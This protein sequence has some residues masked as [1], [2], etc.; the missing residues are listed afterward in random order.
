MNGLYIHVPFCV[1]KCGYCDFHSFPLTAEAVP[2]YLEALE[3]ELGQLP[4][5][6]APETVY[7]GGGTPT[8]LPT[9]HLERLFAVLQR[10]V[11][12]DAVQEWTC[13]ANPGTLDREKVRLLRR[14]GVGR[15]SLGVQS[16]DAA[17]LR[18]LQR[19]HSVEDVMEAQ[20]LLREE[21]FENINMDLMFGVPGV[22]T[23]QADRDVD[24]LIALKPEHISCYCLSYEAGTPLTAM[25]DRG[26]VAEWPDERLS[27]TYFMIRGKLRKAGY[28]H[29]EISNFARPGCECAHNLGYWGGG[30]YLGCGPSAWS[31]WN[32][33]RYGNPPFPA[34]RRG[35]REGG[36]LEREVD[37]LDEKARARERLVMGLRRMDGVSRDTF[38]AQTGYDYNDLCGEAITRLK[39][40][41]HLEESRG[42]LRVPARLLFVSDHIFSE[43]V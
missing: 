20:T 25:R 31:F 4:D 26:E 39:A 30:D 37:V 5:G 19:I 7:I 14:N 38:R 16:F 3:V 2:E 1:C 9:P 23:E 18:R 21:G 41:G 15:I 24:A 27:Q 17:T 10:R 28:L 42:M 40:Q 8:S 33:V 34:W 11:C 35:L 36:V 12:L 22:G 32:G 43:L 13:E 29:Y 6:F